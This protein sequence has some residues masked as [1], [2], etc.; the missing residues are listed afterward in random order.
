MALGLDAQVAGVAHQEERGHMAQGMA[1]ALQAAVQAQT[2]LRAAMTGFAQ[3]D[4]VVEVVGLQMLLVEALLPAEVPKGADMVHVV[5]PVRPLGRVA[6]PAASAV[7]FACPQR[8]AR[9]AR[10]SVAD[11]IV[12]PTT[13]GAQAL[14][15]LVPQGE[16]VA[17]GDMPLLGQVDVAPAQGLVGA[18]ADA[19]VAG[20]PTAHVQLALGQVHAA[21]PAL[22]EVAQGLDLDVDRC[23]GVE[24]AVGGLDVGAAFVQIGAFGDPANAERAIAT[25]KGLG[26]PVSVGV[27]GRLKVILA[28]PFASAAELRDAVALT[29]RNGYPDA[30]PTRG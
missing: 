14:D 27:G 17:A 23:P 24:A 19:A 8:L 15:G 20:G 9:P 1:Q 11:R 2:A 18:K 10:A 3:G 4:E 26:L 16:P 6:E 5:G 13:Q 28:G 7:A 25:L 12:V 22:G 30:Y 29:R 21:R